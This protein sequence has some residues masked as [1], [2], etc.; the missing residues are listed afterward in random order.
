M[1]AG[2]ALLGRNRPGDKRIHSWIRLFGAGELL[3]VLGE[4]TGQPV[5]HHDSCR[6]I[7]L[8]HNFVVDRR[9]GAAPRSRAAA[10]RV[11]ADVGVTVD[12]G[13]LPRDGERLPGGERRHPP[14]S[15]ATG[16]SGGVKYLRHDRP[17]RSAVTFAPERPANS[18]PLAPRNVH[19]DTE[20]AGDRLIPPRVSAWTASYAWCGVM[21]PARRCRGRRPP[22][23]GPARPDRR[24]GHRPRRGY[25]RRTRARC[26]PCGARTGIPWPR[27]R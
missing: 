23:Y 12:G 7:T 26:A 22:G 25:Q 5:Q 13:R 8:S 27:R 10:C 2:D 17:I 4:D 9:A 18:F 24:S 14:V 21:S 1:P 20:T 15:H 3:K 6:W 11:K 19:T 16:T